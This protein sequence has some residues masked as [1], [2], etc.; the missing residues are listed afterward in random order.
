MT[1]EQ[2]RLIRLLNDLSQQ[3]FAE[4][5]NVS[6]PLITMIERGNR[7]VTLTTKR[8]VLEA[9]GMNEE[10]LTQLQKTREMIEYGSK[11]N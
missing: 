6:R 2:L 7:S 8:K 11:S 9:F 3:A 10:K 1:A 4:R 5:L